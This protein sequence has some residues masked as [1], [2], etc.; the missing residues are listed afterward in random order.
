MRLC[1]PLFS[2]LVSLFAAEI[3]WAATDGR[4]TVGGF[5]SREDHSSADDDTSRNDFATA[6]ARLFVRSTELA[7]RYDEVTFDLRDKNDFF[8]KVNKEQLELTNQNDLQVRQA[9][10]SYNKNTNGLYGKVGRF[11]I[12]QAGSAYAD[13][14]EGGYNWSSKLKTAVFGGYN[15][16]RDDRSYLEFSSKATIYGA[17]MDYVP[18]S[19]FW[20][21]RFN[22]ANALAQ[23]SF[24]GQVDRRYWFHNSVLQWNEKSFISALFYI[25]FI[26][27]TYI[28]NASVNYSQGYQKTYTSMLTASAVDVIQYRRVQDVRETLKPS[29]YREVKWALKNNYE[30]AKSWVFTQRFG[31]RDDDNLNR[32]TTSIGFNFPQMFSKR[33]DFY[34]EGSYK[35]EFTKNG[36]YVKGGSGYFSDVW[37]FNLDLELG[38]ETQSDNTKLHPI[39]AEFSAGRQYSRKFFGVFSAQMAKDEQVNILTLFAKLTYRFGGD[40]API[41]DGASPRGRL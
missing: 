15:P 30:Q 31:T 36:L 2:L 16:R 18:K 3:C 4:F 34:S 33:F 9:S 23:E 37:E 7:D 10:Y 19:Q 26:P 6:S 28:Q 11:P 17:Y 12:L 13:G 38:S 27:R 5:V 39:V 25:D 35:H 14:I 8:S 24:D 41:R 32:A 40:T 21:E 22:M 20:Y 29:A 1:L